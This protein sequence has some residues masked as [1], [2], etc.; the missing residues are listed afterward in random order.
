MI[1]IKLGGSVL[2]DKSRY[3]VLRRANMKRLAT[4]IAESTRD[5]CIV[6]GAGSFGH[7]VAQQ[8]LLARGRSE[9]D[10][11]DAAASQVH[12]DVRDLH[13][14]VVAGLAEAGLAPVG[15]APFDFATLREGALDTIDLRPIHR[16]IAAGLMPV[17]FGDLVPDATRG[18]GILSGDVVVEQL[19]RDLKPERVVF[20]TDVDGLYD[21]PPHE[22]DA[23][24]LERVTPDEAV[25]A[26]TAGSRGIDVTGGM[27]GKV[28]RLATI[29]RAG[30]P[31][32]VVNGTKRGRL[33]EALAGRDV[34]GTLVAAG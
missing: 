4:E 28:A 10:A 5:A 6:H 19:A 9:S 26:T 12:R 24:L 22:E 16:A 23:V 33:A 20:A 34:V 8:H 11:Q 17:S 14:R 18:Y 13:A 1:V 25:A 31:V 32:L 27:A 30:V 21:R 7:V 2:T 3:R 15:V 29:A